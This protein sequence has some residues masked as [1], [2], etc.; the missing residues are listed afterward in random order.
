MFPSHAMLLAFVSDFRFG[1]VVSAPHI[2][3]GDAREMFLTTLAHHIVFHAS[4]RAD[5]GLLHRIASPWAGKGRG[6]AR[7]QIFSGQGKLVASTCQ[8]VVLRRP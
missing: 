4:C 6:L 3:P 2:A 8:E 5:E 7:G 1:P